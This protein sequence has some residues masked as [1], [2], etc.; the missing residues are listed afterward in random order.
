M[1]N[2]YKLPEITSDVKTLDE[3]NTHIINTLIS[4]DSVEN[5][6]DYVGFVKLKISK[7][8]LDVMI[9]NDSIKIM[10]HLMKNKLLDSYLTY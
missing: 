4:S 9:K 7:N 3:I 6:F 1:E 8:V 10:E 5:F 2:P